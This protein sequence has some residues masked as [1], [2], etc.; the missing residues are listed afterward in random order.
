MKKI[1]KTC[2]LNGCDKSPGQLL[3]MLSL[4]TLIISA[5]VSAFK[6]EMYLAGTQWMLVS[7]ILAIYANIFFVSNCDCDKK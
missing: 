4:T 5:M 3:M 6:I 7:I 1:K 2:K